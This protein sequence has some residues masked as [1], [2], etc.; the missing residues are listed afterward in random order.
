MTQEPTTT[1]EGAATRHPRFARLPRTCPCG[2][3]R[4]VAPGRTYGAVGC[5]W[6]LRQG[7]LADPKDSLALTQLESSA[8][9]YVASARPQCPACESTKAH[10]TN[11]PLGRL[12]VVE[13]PELK[14]ACRSCSA[15]YMIRPDGAIVF[16]P[17]GVYFLRCV[18]FIK[19]GVTVDFPS[20][21]SHYLTDNPYE[22]ELIGFIPRGQGYSEDLEGRLHRH[23]AALRHRGE[24]FRAEPPL[25]GW[26]CAHAT[27]FLPS[28]VEVLRE[29]YTLV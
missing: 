17:S 12:R 26:I 7:T 10:L 14:Y 29:R 16:I 24:W 13:K 5:H 20:R 4:L 2:C 1:G 15:N 9:A 6:R 25:L 3:G 23:F 28:I 19:I 8:R 21:S 22:I 11:D 27:R 18:D